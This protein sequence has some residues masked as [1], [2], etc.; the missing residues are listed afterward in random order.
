MER[1]L[2]AARPEFSTADLNTTI[3]C[4]AHPRRSD[5]G[6]PDA[7]VLL[8]RSNDAFKSSSVLG[9][10][11]IRD[12]GIFGRFLAAVQQTQQSSTLLVSVDGI[13]LRASRYPDNLA[14][15]EL[16]YTVLE[17]T[18][19]SLFVDVSAPASYER[20][21]GTMLSSSSDGTQF[22]IVL[23]KT[24]RHGWIV[25]FERV[26]STKE[27]LLANILTNPVEASMGAPKRRRTLISFD[28]GAEWFPIPAPPLDVNGN[29]IDCPGDCSLHLHNVASRRPINYLYSA[30]SA[31]G[32]LVA[33]GNTGEFL[34]DYEDARTYV[35]RDAGLTWQEVRQGPYLHKIGDSG[36]LLVLADDRQPTD[37]LRY[38]LNEGQS[39]NDFKFS[40]Q[41]CRVKSISNDPRGLSKHFLLFGRKSGAGARTPFVVIHVDMSRTGEPCRTSDFEEWTV[42]KRTDFADLCFMGQ[43]T[44]YERRRAG[45]TC[46][47]GRRVV[48][49]PR[50][51]AVCECKEWDFECDLNFERNAEDKCVRTAG[52]PVPDTCRYG[53]KY[54]APSGCVYYADVPELS[55]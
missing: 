18:P 4:S 17:S 47:I 24:S 54:S 25:D 32:L 7:S 50:V 9:S 51:S 3:Y 6:E 40:E 13:S 55:L 10:T 53:E 44:A 29:R 30:E 35:S 34:S 52:S 43:R 23:Q 2:F 33:V 21:A 5:S 36:S 38:S 16:T 46:S 37:T 26:Q 12:F 11:G 49:P 1:C 19:S 15:R 31:P 20:L 42:R 14:S 48:P 8:Y 22:S 28:N 39:W 27:I 45:S 41:P